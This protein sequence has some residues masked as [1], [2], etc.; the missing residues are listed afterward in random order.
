[1]QPKVRQHL[2]DIA[3]ACREISD[4]VG[5]DADIIVR[6]RKTALAVE[7]LLLIVGE[8]L[9]RIRDTD[10]A[11]LNSISEWNGIVGMRNAIVHG[12]DA[13]VPSRLRDAIR[14]DLPVL[15]AEVEQL[16]N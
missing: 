4:F 8:A 3:A 14:H 7:R 15:L 5:E 16:L 10:P 6:D 9:T 1:M 2:L 12:Y 13:L 11:I